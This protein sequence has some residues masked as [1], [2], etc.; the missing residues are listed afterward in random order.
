MKVFVYL[1]AALVGLLGLL[2]IV[3][4]GQGN[5]IP[6]IVIGILCMIAAGALAA[7]SRLKPTQHTHVSQVDLS[8]DVALE[9]MTCTQCSGTLGKDSVTV[10]A[11]AVFVNCEYCGAQYQIEEAPK[12]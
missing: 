2:F 12:W 4:A 6:R 10:K 9:Q 1:L 8:G 5:A 3:A 7:L 11:G